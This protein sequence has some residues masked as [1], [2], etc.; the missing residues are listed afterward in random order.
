MRYKYKLEQRVR[1]KILNLDVYAIGTIIGVLN[2]ND[3]YYAVDL[4]RCISIVPE[5]RIRPY[6]SSVAIVNVRNLI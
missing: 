5:Q 4:G 6:E 3:S 1:V 2:Q